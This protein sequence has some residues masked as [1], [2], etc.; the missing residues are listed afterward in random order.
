MSIKIKQIIGG[1]CTSTIG[2]NMSLEPNVSPQ[3]FNLNKSYYLL[4]GGIVVDYEGENTVN[5][6]CPYNSNWNPYVDQWNYDKNVTLT[7]TPNT[8]FTVVSVTESNTN[9]AVAFTSSVLL[10]ENSNLTKTMNANSYLL[11]FGSAYSIDSV[12]YHNINRQS[13]TIFAN[14][15]REVQISTSNSCELIYLEP[16]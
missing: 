2:C 1:G 3:K 15:P 8:K 14:S 6:V 5:V 9:N 12:N 4:R 11:V 7:T 16:I 13:R 10:L